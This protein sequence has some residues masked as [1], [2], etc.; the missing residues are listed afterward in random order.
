MVI[1]GTSSPCQEVPILLISPHSLLTHQLRTSTP[2]EVSVALALLTH[3]LLISC[4]RLLP[5]EVYVAL[6]LLTHYL[7]ISCV[8]LLPDEVSVALA[9]LDACAG[10]AEVVATDAH[11]TEVGT[12]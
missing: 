5:D 10:A 6:A 11:G 2:D 9:L 12:V 3:Y 7:L 1:T 4:V 8:R